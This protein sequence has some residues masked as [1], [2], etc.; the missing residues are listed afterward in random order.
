MLE[1]VQ[2]FW[3]QLEGNLCLANCKNKGTKK[4]LFVT[5]SQPGYVVSTFLKFRSVLALTFFNINKKVLL[6]ATFLAAI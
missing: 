2:A 5:K 6:Q 3:D 4:K 1:S